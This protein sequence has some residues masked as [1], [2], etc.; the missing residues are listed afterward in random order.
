MFPSLANTGAAF[1]V[2]S[3]ETGV[4]TAEPTWTGTTVPSERAAKTTPPSAMT[5][6]C[7]APPVD[8]IQDVGPPSLGVWTTEGGTVTP[9]PLPTNSAA[10]GI[11]DLGSMPPSLGHP[12]TV[13]GDPPETSYERKTPLVSP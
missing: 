4:P 5:G 6:L 8:A 2:D 1:G 10:Y 11:K 7:K 3:T 12:E 9:G 13:F